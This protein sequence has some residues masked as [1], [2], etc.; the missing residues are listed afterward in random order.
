MIASES[1][2]LDALGFTE[3]R[4]INP[5]KYISNFPKSQFMIILTIPFHSFINYLG[6]AI[7]ITKTKITS[8]RLVVSKNITPCIF[9]YVYFARPDSVIDGISVYR[10]RLEMGE[11]LADQVV[12][13]CGD[14]MDIDVVIPVSI[15]IFFKKLFLFGN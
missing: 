11:Y 1:V 7:I 6:E 8:R 10:S 4:D 12:K 5:G 9:E 14:N 13:K 3:V 2:V 15:R